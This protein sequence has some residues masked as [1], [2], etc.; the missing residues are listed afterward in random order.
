MSAKYYHR[1]LNKLY[2]NLV[3]DGKISWV[4][5]KINIKQKIPQTDYVIL[6]NIIG[7]LDDVQSYL[8]KLNRQLKTENRLIV[9]YYNHLWE[10]CLRAA[11][12]F[13]WRRKTKNQNWFDNGD[14]KNILDLAGFETLYQKKRMIFPL[15][16]PFV[17][18]WLNNFVA[19]LPLINALCLT[20]WTVARK[21]PTKT[22]DYS[23]SIIVPARNEAGNIASICRK[24]PQFGKWQ[25]IIFV[26]GHSKDKTWDKIE[27]ERQAKKT[28]IKIRTF[29]Q[30][31]IGKADAVRLGFKKARGEL[32]M[33]LDAD[34]TV[35]P[36]EL[37]KFYRVISQRQA[38][39]VMGGRLIYQ[40][41]EEAMRTLNKLG[42]RIFSWLF[43][44][45]L[46]QRIKDTLC[47]T[48]VLLKKDYEDIVRNRS[49][50]GDFDPFGDFDLIFGAVKQ[51]HK[52]IEIPIRYGERKYGSTNISRFKHGWLLLKMTYFAYQ[53]FKII[54]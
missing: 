2:E 49:Y 45:I 41:E 38:E 7:D 31:G 43:S 5:S 10:V 53:K 25:E 40:M 35:K 29:K 18:K 24:V 13:G 12:W 48:K 52:I 27:E 14:V 9:V 42:N 26:E 21:K 28:K 20:T 1:D 46:S 22:K 32:L 19:Q 3:P 51:N 34:L 44:W 37:L 17:S 36:K 33:I 47:G 6:D 54:D 8:E 16:I 50:F 23:V 39:L 4:I 15:E 11:S 30:K